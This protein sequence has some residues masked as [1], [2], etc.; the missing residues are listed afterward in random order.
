MRRWLT[1]LLVLPFLFNM[2]APAYATTINL[3]WDTHPDPIVVGF[4]LYEAP[5]T[6]G[7]YTLV[8]TLGKVTTTTVLN[9]STQPCWVLTAISLTEESEY[10][11]EACREVPNAPTGLERMP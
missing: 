3:A 9:V 4:K 2:G 7:P 10:S 8:Q 1:Q 11:N 6:G 5:S